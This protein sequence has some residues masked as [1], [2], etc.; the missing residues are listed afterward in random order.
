[1]KVGIKATP[2]LCVPL[3]VKA[4]ALFAFSSRQGPGEDIPTD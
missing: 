1:M 4:P 3:E 2:T